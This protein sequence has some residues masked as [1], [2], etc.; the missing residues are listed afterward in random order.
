MRTAV[1]HSSTAKAISDG[2]QIIDKKTFDLIYYFAD[3]YLLVR[4][5]DHLMMYNTNFE[6]L[7]D[8]GEISLSNKFHFDETVRE[9]KKRNHFTFHFDEG[10]FRYDPPEE[11]TENIAGNS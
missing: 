3:I 11:E 9:G 5:N 8:Y 10:T 6:M 4:E 1:S 7:E 2:N